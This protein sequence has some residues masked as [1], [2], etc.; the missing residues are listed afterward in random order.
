MTKIAFTEESHYGNYDLAEK[1]LSA[2]Y[3]NQTTAPKMR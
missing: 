1:K 2:E 3:T